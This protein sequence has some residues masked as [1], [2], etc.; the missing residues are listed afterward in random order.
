MNEIKRLKVYIAGPYTARNFRQTQRNVDQAIDTG[1]EIWKRGHY[2]FIPHLTHYV[3]IR[4]TCDMRWEDY[5]EWD[6]VW[7]DACDALLFTGA[8]KGAKQELKYAKLK[9]KRIL[10]NINEIPVIPRKTRKP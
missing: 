8:S 5:L 6:R 9:G 1:I 7:L 3:D 2:P 10:F 4:P